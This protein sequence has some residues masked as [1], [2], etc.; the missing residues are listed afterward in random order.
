MARNFQDLDLEKYF[1]EVELVAKLSRLNSDNARPYVGYRF[2]EQVFC[3]NVRFEDCRDLSRSDVSYDAMYT[4]EGV[5]IGVGVKTF[6]IN[7]NLHSKSHKDEKVAEFT[8]RSRMVDF[9]DA[10]DAEVAVQVS[11]W[12]NYSIEHDAK[13][14]GIDMASSYYH[15]LIRVPGGLFIHEE[16]YPLVRVE[17]IKPTDKHGHVLKSFEDKNVGIVYFTDGINEYRYNRSKNVLYKRFHLN[18]HENT[19]VR[20]VDIIEDPLAYLQ[21]ASEA[22]KKFLNMSSIPL[23]TSSTQPQ[24]PNVGQKP[25]LFTNDLREMVVLPLSVYPKSGLNQWNAGGRARSFGE[26]YIPIPAWI[27]KQYPDFFPKG[28]VNGK[29][30]GLPFELVLPDGHK[31]TASACQQNCKALMSTHNDELCRWLF[32]LIDGSFEKAKLRKH[33]DPKLN[34]P[35]TERDLVDA[36]R[37]SIMVI[38][39]TDGKY[40]LELVPFGAGKAFKDFYYKTDKP[41]RRD[42]F[43]DYLN[44]LE[45]DEE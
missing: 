41:L 39:D 5:K 28:L 33:A 17:D 22:Y 14:Y 34:R 16:P 43:V 15:C 24:A 3:R 10:K 19:A 30:T 8:A 11:K 6:V 40:L 45:D 2:V 1:E 12:R 35:Y 18:K 29:F 21:K 31:L 36:G 42:E 32:A 23:P 7:G 20:Q 27:N 9:R 4:K 25:S 37:D 13:A 44:S 26:S 38:R